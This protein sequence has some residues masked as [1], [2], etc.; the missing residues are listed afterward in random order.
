VEFLSGGHSV[1]DVSRT[2][3]THLYVTWVYVEVAPANQHLVYLQCSPVDIFYYFTYYLAVNSTY[4]QFP[5]L[6]FR[7]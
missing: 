6:N 3:G 1:G 7:S 2:Y 4:R 5:I